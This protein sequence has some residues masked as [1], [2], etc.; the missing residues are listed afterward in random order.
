MNIGKSIQTGMNTNEIDANQLAEQ[1]S[2]TVS[3]INAMRNS[4]HA[5][6]KTVERFAKQFG[7]EVSEFVALGEE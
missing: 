4:I 7:M 2:V 5:N 3:W 1:M 6:T